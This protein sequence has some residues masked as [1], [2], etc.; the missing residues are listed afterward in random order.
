MA[1]FGMKKTTRTGVWAIPLLLLMY[2]CMDSREFIQNKKGESDF[3]V[4][5]H[6]ETR[7]FGSGLELKSLHRCLDPQCI[8]VEIGADTQTVVWNNREETFDTTFFV[9]DFLVALESQ[10][11]A[12]VW[13]NHS[14]FIVRVC[15]GG[16]LDYMTEIQDL[17]EER[18]SKIDVTSEPPFLKFEISILIED[19]K[20]NREQNSSKIMF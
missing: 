12:L 13:N 14:S 1:L 8:D 19:E 6:T 7:F 4:K 10:V 3:Q 11:F 16:E 15:S 18:V 5:Y 17:F 20:E 2:G 9:I